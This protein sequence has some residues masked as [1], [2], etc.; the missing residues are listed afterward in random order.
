MD[1]GNQLK[2]YG[3]Q[4]QIMGTGIQNL[5]LQIQ[6][7][8][9]NDMGN[10]IQNMGLEI[11]NIGMKLFNMGIQFSNMMMNQNMMIGNQQFNQIQNFN[12]MNQLNINNNNNNNEEIINCIFV[13]PS[14]KRI[15][16][17]FEGNKT[18]EE[19]I[20]KYANRIGVDYNEYIE[21][22][23]IFFL[24]SGKKINIHETKKIKESFFKTPT[25]YV[26]HAKNL[27]T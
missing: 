14:G 5:G 4:L 20:K 2:N 18:I 1:N 23:K 7:M 13:Q 17:L 15:N 19:L 22:Q 12:L 26:C 3:N 6:N 16:I 9:M 21:N 27:I 24:L 25:I 8:M 10:Q 11:S